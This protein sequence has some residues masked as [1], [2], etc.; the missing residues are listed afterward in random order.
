MGGQESGRKFFLE[1]FAG[2]RRLS[3]AIKRRGLKTLPCFEVENGEE[4]NLLDP[5]VQTFVGG[6]RRSGQVW[7]VHF[8]TPCCIWSRARRNIKNFRKARRQ[9]ERHGVACALTTASM[10]RLCLHHHWR[11]PI[12][13]ACGNFNPHKTASQIVPLVL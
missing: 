3:E 4:F 2:T 11:V 7:Y 6:L 13:V 1:L 8:G 12:Q 5:K 10:T 9:K